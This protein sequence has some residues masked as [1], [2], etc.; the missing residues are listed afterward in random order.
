MKA[1]AGCLR[2]L[3]GDEWQ[4]EKLPGEFYMVKPYLKVKYE[5]C[6][7]CEKM[8]FGDIITICCN[9]YRLKNDAGAWVDIDIDQE[10]QNISHG[11]CPECTKELYPD[12]CD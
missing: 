3:I 12:L 4:T 2:V 8:R 7:E 6:P 1:C 10:Y 5:I 9:C 11:I